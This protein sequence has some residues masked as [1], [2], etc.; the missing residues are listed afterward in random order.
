MTG[1]L[2]V[3][4]A[5]ASA[6]VEATLAPDQ[7]LTFIYEDD[8]LIVEFAADEAAEMEA[9]LAVS[10]ADGA[11][12]ADLRLG[13]FPVRGGGVRW[14]VVDDAPADRGYYGARIAW[15]AG[16]AAT[17]RWTSRLCSAATYYPGRKIVYIEPLVSV[18][19]V[20]NG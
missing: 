1:A 5:L 2:A 17:I 9:D 16:A 15:R 12:L 13:P 14:V 18:S 7:P 19:R 11:P 4:M 10:A 20:A 8:P 3:L 6:G